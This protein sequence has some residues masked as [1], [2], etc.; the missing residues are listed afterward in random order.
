[1]QNPKISFL[2]EQ[3][4]SSSIIASLQRSSVYAPGASE[5]DRL[6]L[7]K[8][9]RKSLIDIAKQYSVLVTE[10]THLKN[11]TQFADNVSSKCKSFLLHGR[12][13]IGIA[14]KALNLYLK[15]LWCLDQIPTPPH[16]PFDSRIITLLPE[17]KQVPWTKFDDITIYNSLVVAAKKIAGSLS[18]SE[19]ELHVYSA[20]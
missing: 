2:I 4:L 10:E 20:V 14:Q 12:F 15:Y 5:S 7:G 19:W 1:M 11:I 16:C 8:I 9:L 3:A 6:E 17:N 13:R 18:L